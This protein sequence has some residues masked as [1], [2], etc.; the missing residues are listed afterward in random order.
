M[1]LIRQDKRAHIRHSSLSASKSKETRVANGSF[2]AR[3]TIVMKNTPVTL[4][5]LEK[6]NVFTAVKRTGYKT[7]SQ[8][9]DINDPRKEAPGP[10]IKTEKE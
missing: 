8:W 2:G 6:L 7:R 3:G 4:M 9:R 10:P 5:P 1:E